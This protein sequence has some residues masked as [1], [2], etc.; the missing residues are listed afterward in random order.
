MDVKKILMDTIKSKEIPNLE[1]QL[2][3]CHPKLI[4]YLSENSLN[5]LKQKIIEVYAINDWRKQVIPIEIF[6]R[7]VKITNI[8]KWSFDLIVDTNE[9]KYITA[10]GQPIYQGYY[11]GIYENTYGKRVNNFLDYWHTPID[12]IREDIYYTNNAIKEI[13]EFIKTDFVKYAMK[14]LEEK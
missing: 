3:K 4:K 14:L 9:L 13:T 1:R 2:E 12:H 7:A 10:E 5:I 11:E 8:G 6:L